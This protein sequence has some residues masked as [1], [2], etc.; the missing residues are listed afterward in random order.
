MVG[1]MKRLEDRETIHAAGK[2]LLPASL[3]AAAVAGKE[4]LPASLSAASAADTEVLPA[5]LSAAADT[6]LLPASLSAAADTELLPASLSA[7]VDT[8]L[9]PASMSAE[10]EMC[11]PEGMDLVREA[12]HEPLGRAKLVPEDREMVQE[13]PRV[14]EDREMGPEEPRVPEDRCREERGGQPEGTEMVRAGNVGA[15]HCTDMEHGQDN[16]VPAPR[17]RDTYHKPTEHVDSG[18]PAKTA[19]GGPSLSSVLAR[20]TLF[21]TV[22][23]EPLVES[24]R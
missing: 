12:P 8:E 3:S 15:P 14:P 4:L 19:E 23:V 24:R 10:T 9:L 7:A 1:K 13:E 16:R 11:G 22:K 2:A 21:P 5:S 6:E 17:G 20:E 18:A